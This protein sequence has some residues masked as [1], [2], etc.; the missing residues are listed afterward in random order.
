MPVVGKVYSAKDY[1]R[2]FK[3]TSQSGM[4]YSKT[5]KCMVIVTKAN[6][7]DCYGCNEH[8][9]KWEDDV[10]HYT[11]QGKIGDQKLTRSNKRLANANKEDTKIHIYIKLS[12]NEYLYEGEAELINIYTACENDEAGNIRTANKFELKLK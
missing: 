11:G 3:C 9:D 6:R 2:E 7:S 8:G 12:P 4:N 5:T 10:L 1:S